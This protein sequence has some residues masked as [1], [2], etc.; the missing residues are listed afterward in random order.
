MSSSSIPDYLYLILSLI[1]ALIT[2]CI[3]AYGALISKRSYEILNT[4]IKLKI[5][6]DQ[7]SLNCGCKKD[8]LV[9][10]IMN[11][12][13]QSH[14]VV[15]GGFITNGS[16]HS[17]RDIS[18]NLNGTPIFVTHKRMNDRITLDKKDVYNY[19]KK[20]NYRDKI[21]IKAFLI[22]DFGNEYKSDSVTL[23]LNNMEIKS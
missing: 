13:D 3:V 10:Y 6:S 8:S 14:G 23:N 4:H 1:L 2:I 5:L 16:K 15:E 20:I 17:F 18:P 7:E 19:F 22:D 21:K 11:L 9:I 12:S